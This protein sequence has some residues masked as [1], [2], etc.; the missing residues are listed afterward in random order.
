MLGLSTSARGG[1]LRYMPCCPVD[2]AIFLFRTRRAACLACL[3]ACLLRLRIVSLF[4]DNTIKHANKHS[5][6]QS[7][8]QTNKRTNPKVSRPVAL[9]G[10]RAARGVVRGAHERLW[11]TFDAEAVRSAIGAVEAEGHQEA[12]GID[13]L[14]GFLRRS[15]FDCFGG[16]S[17]LCFHRAILFSVDPKSRA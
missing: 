4:A 14:G 1:S 13:E 9:E 6:K 11:W 3:P 7:N 12:A 15:G 5:S 8:N 2:Y 17:P 10:V 16:Q